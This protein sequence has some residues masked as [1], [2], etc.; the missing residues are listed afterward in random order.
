[1]G[2]MDSSGSSAASHS[3]S[4]PRR[5]TRSAGDKEPLFDGLAALAL[6]KKD[7]LRLKREATKA[8]RDVLRAQDAMEFQF[9]DKVELGTFNEVLETNLLSFG[10]DERGLPKVPPKIPLCRLKLMQLVRTLQV[11]SSAIARLKS[12]FEM[13]GYIEDAP[14]F[15]VQMVDENGVDLVVTQEI[16][17]AWDPTWVVQNQTFEAE[18]DKDPAFAIPRDRMF[19]VFDGNHRLF[20]WMQVASKYPS[21]FKYHPRVVCLI[22]KGNKDTFLEVEAA[23]HE[24]NK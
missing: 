11:H 12:R 14:K 17:D 1:M 15:Y 23:M 2:D 22:L 18:C 19:V 16:R 21:E 24:L 9:P 3:A 13:H 4:G 10:L 20:C 5:S 7:A 6:A 8:K